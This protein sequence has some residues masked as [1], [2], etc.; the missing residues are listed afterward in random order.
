MRFFFGGI[1][2]SIRL[3]FT[4]S[5]RAFTSYPRSA[6]NARASIPD[7][8]FSQSLQ[9]A[10][11]PDVTK[12]PTGILCASTAKCTLVLSP[13]LRAPCLGSRQPLQQRVG[14]PRNGT[15]QSSTIQH[16][17]PPQVFPAISLRCRCYATDETFHE[18]FPIFRNLTANPSMARQ[19]VTPK[20]QH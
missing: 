12:I 19:Y 2:I 8:N 1:T 6:N 3:N 20:N 15:H 7:I 4:G 16:R 14:V 9:S 13:L 11:V 18:R 10:V 5:I 17:G